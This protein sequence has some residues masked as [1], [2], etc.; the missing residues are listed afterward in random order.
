MRNS[1]SRMQVRKVSTLLGL[2]LGIWLLVSANLTLRDHHYS[3]FAPD[4]LGASLSI[5]GDNAAVYGNR[6]GITH[7]PRLICLLHAAR[8][9]KEKRDEHYYLQY[10]RG[11]EQRHRKPFRSPE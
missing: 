9:S 5:F 6:L 3:I 1:I 2:P 10:K 8:V 11:D 4:V 7:C